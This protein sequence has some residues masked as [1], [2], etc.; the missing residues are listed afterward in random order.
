M[1]AMIATIL[2]VAVLA[3]C[4]VAMSADESG[5]PAG[6]D[7]QAVTMAMEYGL[8]RSQIA[9]FDAALC[10]RMIRFGKVAMER[11]RFLEAKRFFWKALLVDPTSNLAWQCYDQAVVFGLAERVEKS[12]GLVGLPGLL[13]QPAPVKA[14]EPEFEEGC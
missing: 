14:A 5:K 1:R 9:S 6:P 8:N 12:P 11:G 2:A 7:E 13:D 3:L 4:A 10:G